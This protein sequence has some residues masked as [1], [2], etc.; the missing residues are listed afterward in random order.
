LSLATVAMVTKNIWAKQKLNFSRLESANRS[1]LVLLIHN[2]FY[3]N[4]NGNGNGKINT[5]AFESSSR[6]REKP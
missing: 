1:N 3:K 4:G 2:N 6:L 5:W